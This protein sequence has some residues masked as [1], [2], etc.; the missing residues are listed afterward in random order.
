[1]GCFCPF[2][3]FIC[4]V[5]TQG[6]ALGYLLFGLSGRRPSMPSAPVSFPRCQVPQYRS[7]DVNAPVS[8]SRC[9]RPSIVPPMSSSPV[10]FSRCECPGGAKA[11]SP[12][13]R[14]VGNGIRNHRPE[15]AKALHT[16]LTSEQFSLVLKNI[17][18]IKFYIVEFKKLYVFI[19]E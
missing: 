14:P 9:E 8:F 12:G 15:R 16:H 17:L 3:A 18:L 4:C 7:P 10:S 1:M 11:I 13:Q 2:R 5:Y 19:S 6:V